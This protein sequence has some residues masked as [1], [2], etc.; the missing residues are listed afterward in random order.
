MEL[1]LHV[2]KVVEDVGMVE[3]E[4]VQHQGAR[5]VVHELRAF[6]E[7]CGVVLV[8]LD[9]ERPAWPIAAGAGAGVEVE[10]HAG[11]EES[12][13]QAGG[14]EDHREHRGGGGLAVGAGDRDDVPVREHVLGQ[15]RRAGRVS[16]PRVEDVFHTGVAARHRI[17][18][19]YDIGRRRE[20]RGVVSG[21]RRNAGP[22]EHAAHR[23]IH[24][25]VAAGDPVAELAGDQGE[26][27]HEGAAD[28]EKVNVHA[29]R[30]PTIGN[31]LLRT[32]S[33]TQ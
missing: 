4:V 28:A 30:Y 14:V 24:V 32:L 22:V 15:P 25:L 2:A 33:E 17:A 3:F 12:G 8:G 20:L 19:H 10:R 23:R 29:R 9:D 5:A 21:Y 1:A 18:D 31:R 6:V 13:V 26:S 7:E 16:Q 27:G 11:D